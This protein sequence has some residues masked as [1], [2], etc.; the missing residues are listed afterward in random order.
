MTEPSINIAGHLDWL[1][2]NLPCFRYGEIGLI[3]TLRDGV[4]IRCK[5]VYH[6][7]FGSQAPKES[8]V[9]RPYEEQGG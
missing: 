6:E 2:A 9:G 5:R 3:F 1:K 8:L 7:T 4:I